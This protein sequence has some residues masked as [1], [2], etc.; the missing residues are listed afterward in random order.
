MPG[1]PIPPKARS[2]VILTILL[3]LEGS[4][5]F[6]FSPT[7]L[8]RQKIH[9]TVS[10]SQQPLVKHHVDPGKRQTSHRPQTSLSMLRGGGEL[11][12]GLSAPL[13]AKL[14]SG[15]LTINGLALMFAPVLWT[16]SLYYTGIEEDTFEVYLLRAIGAISVGMGVNVYLTV[17]RNMPVER[18]MGFA[19]L[20]RLLFLSLSFLLRKYDSLG[21]GKIF[22]SANTIVMSWTT[23]SLLSGVGN[24]VIAAKLF[25]SLAVL[26]GALL[27]IRPNIGA[28]KF[29]ALDISSKGGYRLSCINL[30]V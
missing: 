28:K 5:G 16:D 15:F 12:T 24:P 6:Q 17:L 20:P 11:A 29:F 3:L 25:S 27:T 26:K 1:I 9:Q 10:F 8:K 23:F 2:C 4:V 7:R 13:T 30:F 21:V 14:C 22:L 19:L 18:A